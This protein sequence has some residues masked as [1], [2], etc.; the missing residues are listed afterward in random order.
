MKQ[1]AFFFNSNNISVSPI[2]IPSRWM[3]KA[4]LDLGTYSAIVKPLN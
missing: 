1:F 4:E 3:H 2:A